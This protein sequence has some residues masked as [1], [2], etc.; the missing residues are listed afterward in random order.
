MVGARGRTSVGIG[1]FTALRKAYGPDGVLPLVLKNCTSVLAPCLVKLFRLCLSTST[2]PSCWKYAYIQPV[3]KKGERSNLSN[4]RPNSLISCLSKIFDSLLNRK[5][6]R[7]LS[8]HNLRS[9]RQYSFQSER[10]IGDLLAFLNDS[11][12]SSFGGFGENFA[13][14]LDISKA[15]DRV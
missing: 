13:V 12:L 10:S 6:Q 9:D 7:H 11:L 1:V 2:Y 3:P 4:Y 15:F 5:I 8:T 14:A